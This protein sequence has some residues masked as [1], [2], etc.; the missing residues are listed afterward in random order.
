MC[1]GSYNNPSNWYRGPSEA[2]AGAGQQAGPGQQAGS[3]VGPGT[4][5]QSATGVGQK[6]GEDG[7]RGWRAKALQDSPTEKRV[8]QTP[9]VEARQEARMGSAKDR[10]AVR[11][12]T[13]W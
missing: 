7:P 5:A 3:V 13:A 1:R 6:A 10:R 11:G 2:E 9:R 4:R 8:G 12:S